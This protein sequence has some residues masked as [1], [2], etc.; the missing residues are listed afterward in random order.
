MSARWTR[1]FNFGYGYP[2]LLFYPPATPTLI[3]FLHFAGL[4]IL[5]STKFLVVI[6]TFVAAFFTYLLGRT[7]FDRSGGFLTAFIYLLLPYR[8][9]TLIS[10][11]AIAEYTALSI[12]P[13]FWLSFIALGERSDRFRI[14]IASIFSCIVL[15]THNA[16]WLLT[17]PLAIIFSF[18]SAPSGVRIFRTSRSMFAILLS[19][20]LCAFYLI[21]SVYE[22]R[23]IQID[24]L[25]TAS[26]L[27]YR[28]N[29]IPVSHLWI[30]TW[31]YAG[32][33]RLFTLLFALCF[34]L[35]FTRTERYFALFIR[36]A[37]LVCFALMLRSSL[38]V[39]DLIKPLQ[40]IQFP[41][42]IAGIAGLFAAMTIGSLFQNVKYPPFR[43]TLMALITMAALY[44]YRPYMF[45]HIF[46]YNEA[47][48]LSSDTLIHSGTTAVVADEYQ[49]IHV[50]E[51][52]KNKHGVAAFPVEI[53]SGTGRV[54][55][56]S[57]KSHHFAAWITTDQGCRLRFNCVYYPGWEARVD[58]RITSMEL[59]E[60]TS[61]M[62]IEIPSGEHTVEW[63]FKRTPIR[64]I[65]DSVSLIGAFSLL[66][67]ILSGRF[68]KKK[69]SLN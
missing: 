42:R 1:E 34:I 15:L 44:L 35:P 41:W 30:E 6:A 33:G 67:F 46:D 17:S 32:F 64:W 53:I 31:P 52:P 27:S 43:L 45:Q 37:P 51:H 36:T 21:P 19:L 39:W 50:I 58:R 3:W 69:P 47:Y 18:L 25:L 20:I 49:P 57:N 7:L 61:L 28:N 8:I 48:E 10:R 23:N 29:T 55:F 56:D 54:F 22:M 13:G 11:G 65:A 24:N 9:E 62:S 26:H 14:L 63:H 2:L 5:T 59:D 12:I 4:S 38:P 40:Y 66:L 68:G 16:T 60:K